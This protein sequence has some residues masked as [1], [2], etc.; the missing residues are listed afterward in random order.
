M[1]MEDRDGNGEWMVGY[2]DDD[3]GCYATILAGP[4]AERRCRRNGRGDQTRP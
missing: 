4:E 1:L 3:G 2:Q